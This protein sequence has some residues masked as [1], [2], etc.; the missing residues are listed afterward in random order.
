MAEQKK[1]IKKN[2]RLSHNDVNHDQR[3]PRS[4]KR[5]ISRSDGPDPLK[6]K[7]DKSAS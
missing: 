4:D 6:I 5:V 7:R 1:I 2:S 3:N